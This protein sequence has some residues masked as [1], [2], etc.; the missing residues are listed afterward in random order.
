MRSTAREGSSLRQRR[1]FNGRSACTRRS[2]VRPVAFF[3]KLWPA[4][5][6]KPA[7]NERLAYKESEMFEIAPGVKVQLE[8]TCM[9]NGN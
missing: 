9:L 1:H 5:T 4:S 3:N 2:V 8:K 7:S 6:A